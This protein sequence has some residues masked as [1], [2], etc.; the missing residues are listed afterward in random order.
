MRSNIY[1]YTAP[2]ANYP[3]Y[4]SINTGF[5]DESK[6]EITLRGQAKDGE[7]GRTVAVSLT[8][9]E[10]ERLA[11]TLYSYACTGKA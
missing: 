6:I 8:F 5:D 3:E 9:G 7:C 2:G 1:A 4:V 10:F 11:R